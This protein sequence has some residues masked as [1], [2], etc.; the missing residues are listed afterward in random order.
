MTR[1]NINKTALW[2]GFLF[3]MSGLYLVYELV[4]NSRIVDG[5]TGEF[6]AS[7]MEALELQGR[8]L[9]GVGLSL[10]CLRFV[11][12][13]NLKRFLI[14]SV[15]TTT[16]AFSL[17]FF[18]QKLLIES[19]VANSTVE[20]RVNAQHIALLKNGIMNRHVVLEDISIPEEAV[21]TPATKA[22]MS[23]VGVMAFGT[24]GFV[25]K[26]KSNAND[27]VEQ[28]AKNDAQLTL[29]EA[30]EAYQSYQSAVN[31]KWLAYLDGV[32]QYDEE[33]SKVPEKSLDKL[34]E[35][36]EEAASGFKEKTEGLHDKEMLTRT[37]LEIKRA[38][39]DY[40]DSKAIADA[41]CSKYDSLEQKC[42]IKIENTY[43]DKVI[44]H[45]GRYVPPNYWCYPEK[46]T[47]VTENIR[48]RRVTS[49]Q[50]SQDCDS[51][52]REW[53]ER[54]LL[55]ITG[56]DTNMATNTEVAAKVRARLAENGIDMPATWR[57]GDRESLLE[58]LIEK[59]NA[60]VDA[61]YKKASI[62]RAGQ[63]I[64]PTLNQRDFTNLPMVQNPIK[65]KL[66]WTKASPVP[67]TLDHN[68]FFEQ[69]HA[70]RYLAPISEIKDE[71][72]REGQTYGDGQ[73]NEEK[74]K[75][76][77]RSII[78]PPFA[79]AFSLFFGLLN[80][81]SFSATLASML[82]K[83]KILG[84]LAAWA[85]VG[86]IFVAYPLVS[87]SSAV[88]SEAF[89]Y[90]STEMEKQTSPVVPHLAAW[91]ID[92]QPIMYPVGNTLAGLAGQES[93]EAWLIDK[94]GPHGG[95]QQDFVGTR[96]DSERLTGD[97][98]DYGNESQTETPS[99]DNEIPSSATPDTTPSDT[100]AFA[101][102]NNTEY[103][104]LLHG[105]DTADS[106]SLA[107]LDEQVSLGR[108]VL[109]DISPI[110]K[111]ENEDWVIYD[112]KM[113]K[114]DVCV[115]GK[116]TK[117]TLYHLRP[118]SW[119]AARHGMCEKDKDN[120]R[121]PSLGAM[122]RAIDKAPGNQPVIIELNETV[123]G[124]VYCNRYQALA[125]NIKRTVTSKPIKW[126]TS[127][128]SVLGCLIDEK[129]SGTD[130]YFHMPKYSSRTQALKAAAHDRANVSEWKRLKA[131][132]HG[133]EPTMSSIPLSTL[134]SLFIEAPHLSGI[135]ADAPLLDTDV[136]GHLK[137]N[138]KSALSLN[139][140]GVI[141][142]L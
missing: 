19:L 127:S 132:E 75:A 120:A 116:R 64:P 106:H 67:L 80:L 40:F 30:Y 76:Y 2:S 5:S 89:A 53:F 10:L 59:G 63:Y 105:S 113:L 94:V 43:R 99:D 56:G 72:D 73:A 121:M 108:S 101:E 1:L 62:E 12:L 18:G 52:D 24:D 134:E 70:P 81:F 8:F 87:S 111:P 15:I 128:R 119:R 118:A 103:Y 95:T 44:E 140:N 31:E 45:A 37:S 78:V 110:G 21:G 129:A 82:T 9:S 126:A 50:K 102:S 48:G 27:I 23:I 133:A 109:V 54:K 13:N 92:A 98:D 66:E 41:R 97:D 49:I 57:M 125:D 123:T 32:T 131:L 33:K 39:K 38:V 42:H 88:K 91:V 3:L 100:G 69:L 74:G 71:L 93:I 58:A 115:V 138:N 139:E 90:F 17:M 112:S 11:S 124:E 68:A 86:A 122:M 114:G 16:I 60:T 35:I 55:E 61:E 6:S 136:K 47:L 22:M 135:I 36:Y 104:S 25:N 26:L 117:D 142:E 51:M 4:F 141:T 65:D 34:N 79:M 107:L 77:Y 84:K 83:K 130:V 20:D 46:E 85:T 7:Q 28:A 96:S 14:T 137:N 29:P